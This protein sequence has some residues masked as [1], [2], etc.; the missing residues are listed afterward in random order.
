MDPNGYIKSQLYYHYLKSFKE[1]TLE[2]SSFIDAFDRYREGFLEVHPTFIELV[3][4]QGAREFRYNLNS[5]SSVPN[6]LTSTLN[7]L[8]MLYYN[9]SPNL[10][11]VLGGSLGRESGWDA[12][13]S[14][15]ELNGLVSY[16]NYYENLH[17]VGLNFM[18][19]NPFLFFN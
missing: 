8:Q 7:Y 5:Y 1:Y 16:I 12:D 3:R 10:D 6:L 13:I 9:S 17:A 18:C 11:L 4:L 14:S 19:D 15:L 2:L